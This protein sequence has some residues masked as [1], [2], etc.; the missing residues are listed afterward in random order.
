[1]GFE[2][3]KID[4]C[5]EKNSFVSGLSGLGEQ[6]MLTQNSPLKIET[7]VVGPFAVNCYL[8]RAPESSACAII[9]PGGDEARIWEAIENSGCI[10]KMILL[11]HGHIDHLLALHALLARWDVP[12]LIH[13]EEKILLQNLGSQAALLGLAEPPPVQVDT[14]L[15]GGDEIELDST[16][17]S[18]LWTPGHSPGSAAFVGPEEVFVGDTLFAG[19]VGRTDLPGGNA[20][21]LAQS[22]REKLF[23]LPGSFVVYPGHGPATTIAREKASNPFVGFHE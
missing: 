18:V 13:R 11:T 17:L 9:D 15:D 16:R 2:S 19:S 4:I 12:V 14:Y 6:Q 8:L 22:I 1:M 10:P 3:I 23:S 21:Q 20:K 7:L 5:L